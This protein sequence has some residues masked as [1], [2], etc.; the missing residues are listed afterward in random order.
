MNTPWCS[1]EVY[2]ENIAAYRSHFIYL[3]S[4]LKRRVLIR[5]PSLISTS[6][7]DHNFLI[8]HFS[9]YLSLLPVKVSFDA[10]S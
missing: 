1:E 7:F 4:D 2:L 10:S 5:T 6:V 3:T 9:D 8:C